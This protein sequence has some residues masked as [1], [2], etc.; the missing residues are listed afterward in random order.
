MSLLFRALA[1]LCLV[2]TGTAAHAQGYPS[3][4]ITFV[5]PFGPGSGSDLIARIIG[6]QPDVIVGQCGQG[7]EAQADHRRQRGDE[8]SQR[9]A[10]GR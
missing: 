7:D 2:L 8:Y 3:K 1:V 4:P 6:Q 5:V 9:P 10:R